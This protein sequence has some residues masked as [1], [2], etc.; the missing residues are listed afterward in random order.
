MSAP[1]L[2]PSLRIVTRSLAL[3]ATLIA[4]ACAAPQELAWQGEQAAAREAELMA[5]DRAF[6]VA[7]AERGLE[8]WMSFFHEDA[9][10][11]DSS[12][13]VHRGLDAI[14]ANDAAIFADPSLQLTWEPEH[15]GVFADGRHGYTWGRFQ[16]LA[17]G[18][19]A[20]QVVGKGWYLSWWRWQDGAWKVI[21]DTGGPDPAP[22]P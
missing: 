9:S 18:G 15:A 5:A 20:D 13:V 22:A 1:S 21:L 8:G 10:R 16:V 3:L 6:A 7:A 17:K 4:A 11:P 12:G 19:E 2:R 14:R